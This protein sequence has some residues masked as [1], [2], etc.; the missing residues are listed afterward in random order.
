VL[1]KSKDEVSLHVQNFITLIEN[2]HHITPKT[3]RTDNGPKFNLPAFDASK[4]ILHQKYCVETLQQNSRVER[5]HQHI[6]NVGR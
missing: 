5:K 1:L 4:G 2:Q 6:F 3:V